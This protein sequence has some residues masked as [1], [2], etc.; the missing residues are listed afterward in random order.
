MVLI[1]Q[2]MLVYSEVEECSSSESIGLQFRVWEEVD[3]D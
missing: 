1:V 3:A 2:I